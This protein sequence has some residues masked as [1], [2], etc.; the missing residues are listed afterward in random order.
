MNTTTVATPQAKGKRGRPRT[1]CAYRVT[2]PNGEKRWAIRGTCNDGSRSKPVILDKG[3]SKRR[4]R[5]QAQALTEDLVRTGKTRATLGGGQA[6]GPQGETLT[7]Y[8]DRWLADREARGYTS[9][10][11]DRGRLTKWVLPELG[12]RPMAGIVRRDLEQLVERLDTAVRDGRIEWKTAIHVWSTVAKLFDDATNGKVLA[13]RVLETDPSDRVRG[14]DRGGTKSKCH[15]KPDELLAV[16]QLARA[17]L[18]TRRALVLAVYCGLRAG[19]LRALGWDDIDLHTGIMAVH[20]A[21]QRNGEDGTTKTDRTR[22]FTVERT[23]LPL[24]R[25]MHAEAEARG[26]GRGRVVELPS[27]KHLGAEVRTML[28]QAGCTRAELFAR[29]KTRR[30][31][32]WHNLRDATA[33]WMGV[34]GDPT[35]QIQHRLGHTDYKMTEEYVQEGAAIRDGYGEVFPALPACLLGAFSSDISS[36]PTKTPMMPERETGLEGAGARLLVAQSASLGHV[37]P[38]HTATTVDDKCAIARPLTKSLTKIDRPDA[39]PDGAA[40]AVEVALARAIDRASAAGQW[41]VVAQLARELEAR[42]LAAAGVALIGSESGSRARAREAC[43]PDLASGAA[44]RGEALANRRQ[45]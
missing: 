10:K 42:R 3:T 21:E 45:E 20:H 30:P 37:E 9:V 17:P 36:Q 22:R 40:D 14:P 35:V 26:D 24:L 1:G 7:D 33:T 12:P 5:E 29:S 39:A 18:E 38:T 41:G 43:R 2:L 13:L 16:A 11:D 6:P 34:R 8:A 15:M 28:R 27:K 32:N 4:A 31:L 19:E 25:A 44:P 23:V